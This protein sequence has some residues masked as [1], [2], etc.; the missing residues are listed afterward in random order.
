MASETKPSV[1]SAITAN[2]A[3]A[4]AKLLAGLA[5]GS[6]AMLAEAVHSSIDGFNDLLLLFGLKRSKR[7]ADAQHPFG[8]GKELYFWALIVSCSVLAVGGGV[9][10]AEGIRSV[11]KPEPLK[12]VKWALIA[13]ACGVAFDAISLLFSWRKFRK[14]NQ[15]KGFREAVRE[16]KDP[17]PL[18]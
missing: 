17:A 5:G 4:G 8:Y 18:M 15:G 1:I 10:I 6:S 14:N 7:P 12:G 16:I 3:I 2:F 11:M 9:T 13:L